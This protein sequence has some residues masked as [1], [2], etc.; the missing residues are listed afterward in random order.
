[1]AV[2]RNIANLIDTS[3][4]MHVTGNVGIGTHDPTSKLEIYTDSQQNI[5]VNITNARGNTVDR[6]RLSL[7]AG[8]QTWRFENDQNLDVFKLR[9]GTLGRD[10]FNIY[11]GATN[12]SLNINST[13]VGVGTSSPSH[14][15]TINGETKTNGY[16]IHL[17]DTTSIIGDTGT[18]GWSSNPGVLMT[19]GGEFRFHGS[20]G[21]VD[22]WA[23][24]FFVLGISKTVSELNSTYSAAQSGSIAYVSDDGG[25]LYFKN[26]S[27]WKSFTAPMGSAS[28][29]ATS[30][31][32][33]IAA[34]DSIGDGAYYIQTS[35]GVVQTYCM[36]SWG[37]YMLAMKIN[38]SYDNNFRYDGG[39]WTTTS[40][41]NESSMS[42]SGSA[43]AVSRLYYDFDITDRM[44]VSLNTFNNYLDET[45]G[46]NIVG[47]TLK[48]CMTYTF[49]TLSTDRS[50]AD[51]LNWMAGAGTAASN[52]DNQP[53][54]NTR[55]FNVSVSSGNNRWG[56]SMN[57]EGDCSSNDSSVGL[58]SHTNS[59][60]GG[61]T[62]NAGGSSWSP[63]QAF[64][65]NAWVW[66]K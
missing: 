16:N 12:N 8:N 9:D 4:N 22:V 3:G 27:S 40:P 52:W 6:A 10:V 20:P 61:R 36:M 47:K 25:N 17:G 18:S 64:H 7:T 24:G 35:S 66:V 50:R 39:N 13:G 14:K 28:N 45:S 41:I 38:N 60:Y 57:N 2:S 32:A 43:D 49:N 19:N 33:I 42:S 31:E 54:C 44:R 56:I 26:A 59:Y 48:E 21:N 65:Y 46:G 23:D 1:M 53:N 63:D 11:N 51:F 55:G 30:A 15:L 34:G 5:D 29:P 62:T 58:G 37:G